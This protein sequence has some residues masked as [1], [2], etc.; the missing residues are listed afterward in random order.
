MIGADSMQHLTNKISCLQKD[1]YLLSLSRIDDVV[2]NQH[3]L[4]YINQAL[5]QVAENIQK[6]TISEQQATKNIS[7]VE[8]IIPIIFGGMQ[9]V[10]G[11]RLMILSGGFAFIPA[12]AIAAHGFNTV[13]ENVHI[14]FDGDSHIGPV[15]R[16]YHTIFHT[17]GMTENSANIAYEAVDLG[18]SLYAMQRLVLKKDSWKLFHYV[19]TDYA[20]AY[21]TMWGGTLAYEISN[22]ART[23]NRLIELSNEKALTDNVPPFCHSEYP[24]GAKP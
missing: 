21:K 23:V 12:I 11:I 14:L 6:G 18:S 19:P 1:L 2:V 15:R 8:T 4:F 3:D 10:G 17:F 24:Y 22:D 5:S 16:A 20:R 7:V 13:Y 9:I